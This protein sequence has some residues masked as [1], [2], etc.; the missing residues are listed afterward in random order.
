MGKKVFVMIALIIFLGYAIGASVDQNMGAEQII[1]E[2]GQAGKIPFPHRLHQ[3]TIGN[4]EQCHDMFAQQLGSIEQLKA[5]GKLKKKQ[6]MNQ[7]CT[8]CHREKNNEG[9]KSGPTSCTGCHH[10]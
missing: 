6:V 3:E 2:G 4:C 8:R 9:V 1:L 7:N 10:K 5:E